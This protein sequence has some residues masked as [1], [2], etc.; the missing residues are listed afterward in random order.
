M[1]NLVYTPQQ[2]VYVRNF[3][4]TICYSNFWQSFQFIFKKTCE[5]GLRNKKASSFK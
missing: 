1:T 2:S 3:V 5:V 4:K